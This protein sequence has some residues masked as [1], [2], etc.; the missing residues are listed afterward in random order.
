MVMLHLNSVIDKN[1][2][3]DQDNA[4]KEIFGFASF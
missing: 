1:N 4:V 3:K 2:L